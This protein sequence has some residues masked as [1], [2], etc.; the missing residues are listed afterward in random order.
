MSLDLLI[1]FGILLTLVIYLIFTRSKFEKDIVQLYEKKFEEWKD[2]STVNDKEEVPHKELV[3]LLYKTK[4][5]LHIELLDEKVK[6]TLE[7]G[8]FTIN[9]L[10]G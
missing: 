4:Y 1:P 8:K 10:K 9:N 5:K 6:P 7:K 3:G 2:T